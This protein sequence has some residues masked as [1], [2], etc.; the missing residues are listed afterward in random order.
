MKF[1]DYLLLERNIVNTEDVDFFLRSLKNDVVRGIPDV[2]RNKIVKWVDSNLKNYLLREYPDVQK[3]T[4]AYS[5]QVIAHHKKEK[6]W[7]QKAM[8][9][10]DELFRIAISTGFLNQITH[11]LDYFAENPN[12]NIS[13]ISV[14][15]AIRQS[16][17]WTKNLN[18]KALDVEDNT[19]TKTLRKYPDGFRWVEVTSK[20][21]LDREGKIMGHCVGSYYDRVSSGNTKIYSLRD[22][23]NEP[24]CTIEHRENT[25]N[26]IKGKGNRAVDEKYIKYC[27]DFVLNPIKGINFKEVRNLGN[28]G[29]IHAMGRIYDPEN[30]P[31]DPDDFAEYILLTNGTWENL[32]KAKDYPKVLQF[33]KKYLVIGN[34][35]T[36]TVVYK[37]KDLGISVKIL[38]DMNIK[39]E[40]KVITDL[41]KTLPDPKIKIGSRYGYFP[42]A[43]NDIHIELLRKIHTLLR[44]NPELK[45][46]VKNYRWVRLLSKEIHTFIDEYILPIDYSTIDVEPRFASIRYPAEFF[47]H[48]L[49]GLNEILWILPQSESNNIRKVVFNHFYHDFAPGG[50]MTPERE[51]AVKI[52][53]SISQAVFNFLNEKE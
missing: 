29:L 22:K 1:L 42:L 40:P 34:D 31:T 13:R 19:G 11:V 32:K 23:K 30:P 49:N 38:R 8:D 15:E 26:Q 36:Y 17:E 33:L 16:D 53:T 5:Q 3:Y 35:N 27:K 44:I 14:P 52:W 50:P 10:G 9:R 45:D 4:Q 51:R 2:H 46:K 21:S 24:H 47:E 41:L 12:I 39:I 6:P 18:K 43:Y 37:G 20:L 7:I 48:S 28:I 25:I